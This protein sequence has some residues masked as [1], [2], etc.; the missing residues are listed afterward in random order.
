MKFLI[1]ILIGFSLTTGSA[2]A[3]YFGTSSVSRFILEN[4]GILQFGI[5][6]SAP[7]TCSYYGA[8]F[9]LDT[10]T[11]QGSS[12]Y[13]MLLSAKLSGVPVQLWYTNTT[14]PAGSNEAGGCVTSKLAT[15]TAVALPE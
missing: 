2:F 10:T 9:K 1:N 4:T 5:S 13:A 7:N 8:F 11:P 14:A 15:I 12:M 6:G 3:E